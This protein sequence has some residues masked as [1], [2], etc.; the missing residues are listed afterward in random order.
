MRRTTQHEDMQNRLLAP[1][2]DAVPDRTEKA[3]AGGLFFAILVE[4][5]GEGNGQ[6]AYF[7]TAPPCFDQ[8]AYQVSKSFNCAST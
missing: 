2:P 5:P 4:Y 8:L 3:L 6:A 7:R 1:G